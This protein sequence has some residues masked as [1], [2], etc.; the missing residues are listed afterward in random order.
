MDGSLSCHSRL[1]EDGNIDR[2]KY[3]NM[4]TKQYQSAIADIKA[5]KT[6]IIDGATGTELQRR[7]AEMKKEAWCA[8]ATESHPETL[9]QIHEDYIRA[10]AR[11]ITA[12]T[13]SSSKEILKTVGLE[14]KF[15]SLNKQSADIAVEA[16]ARSN[17]PESILVAGSITQIVPGGNGTLTPTISDPAQFEA[18]CTE[19]AIIHKE[20]GCD[21]IIAE[22]V[23]DPIYAPC[24]IRAAKA[25][26]LPV[27]VGLT[28]YKDDADNPDMLT[29]CATPTM[30]LRDV[31][32][33]IV[34]AGGDVIGI[35]HT[36]PEFTA[37]AIELLKQ[38][39]RGPT[40]AY[41]DSIPKRK[42]DE[43]EVNLGHVIS[44][45]EFVD[46]SRQWRGAGANVLGGCCGLTV[47]HIEAL[48]NAMS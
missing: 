22:M 26:G 7:G 41:P 30:P 1:R 14:H 33:P 45:Q 10:G 42:G 39:W 46:Y 40:M 20:A 44:E 31:I 11:L 35:M 5:G 23:G 19:M 27:W 2:T 3:E 18:D 24:L 21:L 17:D 32:A 47:S 43:A 4:T 37:E 12:N 36:A 34:E 6:F 15:I 29:A 48:T 8:L 28:A 16:R 9:R 13:F 38:Y 25:S